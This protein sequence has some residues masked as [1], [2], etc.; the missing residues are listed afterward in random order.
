[1]PGGE[2]DIV[3]IK[4]MVANS[5]VIIFLIKCFQPLLVGIFLIVALFA[6]NRVG[7]YKKSLK[8]Y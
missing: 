3:D 5:P 2:S 4:A 1:M 7:Q 6:M 8:A